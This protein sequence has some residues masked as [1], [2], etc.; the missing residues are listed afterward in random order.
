MQ[1]ICIIIIAGL[2]KQRLK[3]AI[4]RDKALCTQ[5]TSLYSTEMLVFLDE[6]GTDRQERKD[7]VSEES[8]IVI[9]NNCSI[10]HI[11]EVTELIQQTG[12]LCI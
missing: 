6:T 8:H 4:Q 3:Y 5:F 9:M 10:H 7:I 11:D 2:T 12:A 1:N